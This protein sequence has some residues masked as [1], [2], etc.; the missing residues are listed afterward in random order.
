MTTLAF[1]VYGT[2][3]D[4]RGIQMTLADM[5]GDD[6]L[7]AQITRRWREKQLEYSFRR[8][9]MAHYQ[10]FS[11]CTRQALNFALSEA[12]VTLSDDQCDQL[13][14][15]YRHLP[16]FP[17]AV[18]LLQQLSSMGVRAFA[19]TNG[20]AA[21]ASELLT[22]AGLIDELDGIV[23]V[24]LLR[25]FKPDPRVYQHFLETADTLAADTW[26]ISGNPFDILGARH[27]GWRTAWVRRT[28][29]PFDPWDEAPDISVTCLS[30]LPGKLGL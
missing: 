7:A 2:L 12:T 22:N 19:F 23:S 3:I 13:L 9:L 17:D 20:E 10:P 4:T 28:E 15:A 11:V 25:T 29:A 18:G 1:D 27:A 21:I 14:M 5:L 30:D 26:L 24:D 8:A 6:P 16:A